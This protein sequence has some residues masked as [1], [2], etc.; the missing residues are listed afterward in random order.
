MN[1]NLYDKNERRDCSDTSSE[2][3]IDT[4]NESSNWGHI[5]SDRDSDGDD[6][7][8]AKATMMIICNVKKKWYIFESIQ[9]WYP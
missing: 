3:S 4:D 7:H 1:Y 6:E 2:S 9:K 5:E 8:E